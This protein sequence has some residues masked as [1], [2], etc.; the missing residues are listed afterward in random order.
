MTEITNYQWAKDKFD[1][2]INKPIDDFNHLQD[3][4]RYAIEPFARNRKLRTIN[5]RILGV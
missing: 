3:A 5:K 2:S 4:M 1:K